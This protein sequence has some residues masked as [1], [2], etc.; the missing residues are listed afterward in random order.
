MRWN[1]VASA[2]ST[3]EKE[4]HKNAVEFTIC[5]FD[6]NRFG[7]RTQLMDDGIFR[8]SHFIIPTN[9]LSDAIHSTISVSEWYYRD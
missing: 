5:M 2:E 3:M 1:G 6:P 7:S 9:F 8:T 4:V